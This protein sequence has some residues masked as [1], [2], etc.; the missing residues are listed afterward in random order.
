[1]LR[2]TSPKSRFVVISFQPAPSATMAD[3][4]LFAVL[5]EAESGTLIYRGT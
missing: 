2:V 4:L 3:G 5:P 1:M